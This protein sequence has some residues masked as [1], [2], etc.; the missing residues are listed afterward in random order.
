MSSDAM[1]VV[2]CIFETIWQLFTSWHI[3]GT[4]V[5]PLE[6]GLFMLTAAIGLSFVYRI[7]NVTPGTDNLASNI[8]RI[9]ESDKPKNKIG[10]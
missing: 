10:F 9:R 6:M 7:F 1:L 2:K 3:P 5:T 8:Q 4:Q